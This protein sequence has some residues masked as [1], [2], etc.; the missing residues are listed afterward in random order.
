MKYTKTIAVSQKEKKKKEKKGAGISEDLP[1]ANRIISLSHSGLLCV[2]S[3]HPPP[4]TSFA[5]CGVVYRDVMWCVC[6]CTQDL[7]AR[8][9][10]LERRGGVCMLLLLLLLC[11]PR[12]VLSLSARKIQRFEEIHIYHPQ[13]CVTWHVF[14]E[15]CTKG[16]VM[17]CLPLL[18]RV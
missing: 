18:I 13:P 16:V 8:M 2:L 1:L 17:M 9:E 3:P 5:W 4:L 6:V 11:N 12:E 15:V 10:L 14:W 7:E